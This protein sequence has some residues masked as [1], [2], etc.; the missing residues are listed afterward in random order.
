[1]VSVQSRSRN[2]GCPKSVSYR[3]R[4][5]EKHRG[6]TSKERTLHNW[7][8]ML[9]DCEINSIGLGLGLDILVRSKDNL[10]DRKEVALSVGCQL[11]SKTHLV[12]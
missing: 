4:F 9:S 6:H 2:S 5:E 10:C 3:N 1:M 7:I 11:K 8:N 12:T